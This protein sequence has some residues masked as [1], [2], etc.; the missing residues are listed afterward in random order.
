MVQLHSDFW[1]SPKQILSISDG[2][3]LN[4]SDAPDTE[5]L[6]IFI[7]NGLRGV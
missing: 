6:A 7:A 5:L 1:A 3:F 2:A 4:H